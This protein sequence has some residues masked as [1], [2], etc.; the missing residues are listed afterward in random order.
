MYC[1]DWMLRDG[2]LMT[3]QLIYEE[4]LSMFFLVF[5][6]RLFDNKLKMCKEQMNTNYSIFP[7]LIHLESLKNW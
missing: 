2:K 1:F 4:N 3:S 6:F 7:P 5:Q